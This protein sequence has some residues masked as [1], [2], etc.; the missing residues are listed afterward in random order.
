MT[1]GIY[2]LVGLAAILSGFPGCGGLPVPA[3]DRETVVLL[4]ITVESGANEASLGGYH[5]TISSRQTM[6][7]LIL[8]I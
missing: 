4:P 8:Q 6:G 2:L 3:P 7:L 5:S 1:K